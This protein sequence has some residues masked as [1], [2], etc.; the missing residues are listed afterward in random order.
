MASHIDSDAISKSGSHQ[1]AGREPT[2]PDQPAGRSAAAARRRRASSAAA[3]RAV[4]SDPASQAVAGVAEADQ[5]VGPVGGWR[6]LREMPA[7]AVSLIVQI[8]ALLAMALIT[9]TSPT[10]KPVV[11]T[12]STSDS[13]EEMTELDDPEIEIKDAPQ[14]AADPATDMAMPADVAV[15]PMPVVAAATDLDVAASMNVPVDISSEMPFAGDIMADLGGASGGNAVGNVAG[16]VGGRGNAAMLAGTRGG[17]KD[18]EEAVDRAL[19]WIADHQ[20]P[21]GSWTF[22]LTKCPSCQGQCGPPVTNL[23]DNKPICATAYALLPFL[24]RGNTHLEGRYKKQVEAGIGFLVQKSV[25]RGGKFWHPESLYAQ[26]VAGIA[27]SECFALSQDPQLAG[28]AQA[29]LDEIMATQHPTLGGWKYSPGAGSDM[30][31][32]VFQIMALKSGQMASLRVDKETIKKAIGYID[33]MQQDGGAAY[34]YEEPGGIRPGTTAA[35][36]LCRMYLGWDRNHPALQ[37]GARRLASKQPGTLYDDYYATQFLHHMEGPLW[38]AWNAKMKKLLLE[39]QSTEGHQAGSWH[40]GLTINLLGEQY[41]RLHPTVMATL[42]LEVYYRHLP[43]F[44]DQSVGRGF[45]Q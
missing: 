38:E 13:E 16:G 30:S 39:T 14:E 15:E 32:T 45:G 36:L 20:M 5:E 22:D 43:L 8:V 4:P 11:I 37:E 28:P 35:G 21:D 10:E 24:G 17:G 44:K 41:G 27:L 25:E 2:A 9:S 3:S 40:E 6:W 12:A 1:A 33:S 29:V 26:A 34:G 23:A 18:T 31:S 19:K 7:W 42:I